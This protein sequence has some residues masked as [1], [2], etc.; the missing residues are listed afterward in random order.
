MKIQ[1][2]VLLYAVL[3]LAML[4]GAGCSVKDGLANNRG[5]PQGIPTET[6]ADFS[7][8]ELVN[9]FGGEC[10]TWEKYPDDMGQS[11][12][13]A[14]D[15]V[16]RRGDSGA[17]LKLEYNV[18]SPPDSANG[19]WI[20]LGNL[21]ASSYDHFEFWVKGDE[22]SGFT[23]L[24]KIEF[25]KT[26]KD[27]DGKD[28]SIQASYV[29]KGVTGKWQKISIPLPVM[30]GILDWHD[31][32]EF[33][34]SFEKKRVDNSAGTLY[35]DDF[36]FIK[37]WM[38]GP[39]IT[40][41]VPHRKKKTDKESN[42]EEFARFLAARLHG[43]PKEV[44][45]KKIFPEDDREFLMELAR[46]TWKYFDKL[47]DMEYA[48]PIDNIRFGEACTISKE[49]R[50]GDYT[51]ITNIGVY[52]MC[53][54]SAYDLGFITR[55]DAVRRMDATLDSIDILE[56]YKGFP[57]NYYDVTIFQ[58]TSNF[59]SFVDSGWLAAGII[60][61][62]NAFPEEL[63][64]KCDKL[65]GPMDF[66]LFYDPVEGHMYHGYYTN[67]NYYS[68]YQYGVLY[69]EPRAASYIAIGKGDV[70]KEH[71]FAMARTFPASW[72]WQTQMPIDRKEKTCL[73]F[74]FFGGYY[75]Y[76]GTK[77]VPSWGG[78]MFEALMPTLIMEEK[79]LAPKGLGAN[80]R[81]HAIIQVKYALE[82]LKYPAFGM[83]PSSVP[84]GGY[85]EYGVKVLGTKGYKDGVITPHASFLAL[86]FTPKESI[87]NLRVMLDKYEC[88]GEYG[89]YDAITVATGK[90][91]TAYLCLDQAMSFIALNN[92]LN[93]GA[94]RKRFHNDP[95]AKNAEELL[96]IEDFF[97]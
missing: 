76:E 16:T 59:I 64:Q 77:F 81:A 85:S 56:K 60:V 6:I 24:F 29:V 54:V 55:E 78:S 47:V 5:I 31:L 83:S 51:N 75:E 92:Y 62:K 70:P 11:I 89:F 96:K 48:L 4:A 58:R 46:D 3:V 2:A 32:K 88:Y 97:E 87:E 8:G 26:Q 57:Y 63:G 91:A 66:S 28:E 50:V 10:G 94:I 72:D 93:D 20:P 79:S 12:A 44:F 40:D 74:K 35:F 27:A 80:D 68:E 69:T 90:A 37:T 65:L 73:G 95:I 30:N 71:W 23:T 15:K 9:N 34:I 14:I 82:K 25:K 49:T 33:V 39:K 1:R 45:V 42:P 19:F 13:A 17:A 43:F 21:D 84:E 67:I 36:A 7:K 38:P 61:A 18:K 22:K 41:I 53:V 86:E 52:L